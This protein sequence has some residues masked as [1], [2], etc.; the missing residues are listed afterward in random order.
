VPAFAD[1]DLVGLKRAVRAA[2]VMPAVFAFADRVIHDP[3]TTLFAVFGS[4]AMLVLADFRGPP[5]KRLVV[6]LVL[7]AT[8]AVFITVATLCSRDPWLATAAMAVVGFAVLFSAA[9][10]GYFAAAGF[11]ALLAFILPVNVPA[12]PAAI[13]SRLEGW[14]LAG[15]VAITAAML[16]WPPR[17]RDELRAA[18]VRAC[19]SLAD[20]VAAELDTDRSRMSDAAAAAR[21]AVAALRRTFVSSPYRPTASAGST[22]ALAFLVDQLDWFLSVAYPEGSELEAVS[23]LCADENREV[24]ASVAAVLRTSA[25]TLDGRDERPDLA[26]LDRAREA[27]ADR[28][29]HDIADR[30]PAPGDPA[31]ARAIAPSFR[32]REMSLAAWEIGRNAMR[33]AGIGSSGDVPRARSALESAIEV[34]REHANPRSV[35]FRNSVRGAAALAIAVTIAQRAGVQHAFWVVLAS[36]SVLRSNALGIRSSVTSAVAGTALGLAIGVGIVL[37]SGTDETVLWAML[38][39]AVLVAAYAPQVISFAAGQAGFTVTLLILFNII[40]PTGWTVGLIRVED[41]AIGFAVSLV[42]GALFWPRGAAAVLRRDLA[43]SYSRSVDYVAVAVDRIARGAAAN[44]VSAARQDARAAAHRLE[45]A[46]RQY[47]AERSAGPATLEDVG[48]LVTGSTRA[49]LAARSLA[50][51]DPVA[52]RPVEPH[53]ADALDREVRRVRSWYAGLGDALVDA[54]AAPPPDDPDLD[55]MTAVLRCAHEAVSRGDEAGIGLGLGLL[56]ASQELDNLRRLESHLAGPADRLAEHAA[57]VMPPPKP[58]RGAGSRA[59]ALPGREP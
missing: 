10:G 8:G 23:G 26:R 32:T 39:V 18:A 2:I 13:P 15:G 25:A 5:R 17:Q 1:P 12:D 7:W 28:L 27:V 24:L 41:V 42:V 46:F 55:E 43:A 57:A 4:F 52:E 33:A 9:L 30:P 22:E 29:V 50:T 45:D 36:L 21:D 48:A 35:V 59:S 56:W 54:R 44:A 11:P 14:A 19:A 38:P 49:R 3:D 53:C 37:A 47:L 31:L 16:V 34:L 20:L 40:Q 58:R 6:Y 51:I